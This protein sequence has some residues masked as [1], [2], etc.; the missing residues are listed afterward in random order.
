MEKSTG[1]ALCLIKWQSNM[2]QTRR[3]FLSDLLKTGALTAVG[4][5][6]I[7]ACSKPAG[8]GAPKVVIIG[9]GYGGATCAKYIR[10]FDPD[11]N[12]TLVEAGTRYLTC[13]F[14]NTVL[15][16]MRE[17]ASITLNY[18]GLKKNYG[19]NVIHAEATAI[20]PEKRVVTLADGTTLP[21]QRLVISPG[22][23]Y[24]WN[25]FFS[26]YDETASATMPH[27]WHGGEQLALLKQQLVG[28]RNGGVFA[29]V[30]PGTPFRCP[31][32]PYERASLV[33]HY[34]KQAN[35]R[36]KVLILD[37]NEHFSKQDLFEEAWHSLYSGMIEH[38][39]ISAG[40]L[41]S[42][43]DP[44]RM[45]LQAEAGEFKVDV[46]NVIPFQ[47]A[48]RLAVDHGLADETG[49]CPVVHRTFASTIVPDIHVLGDSCLA[50]SMPKSASSANSQAKA[51]SLAVISLLR[52]REPGA[53]FYHNTCYSLVAPDYGISVNT[54]YR[55]E[56]NRIKLIERAGG[57]SPLKASMDYRAREAA[58]A[59]SWYA[60]INR[61]SFGLN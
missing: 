32:G 51:C 3:H 10:Y 12:V 27:A 53:M 2:A 6:L 60:S 30:V 36:A 50:G 20:H 18:A 48:G 56:D 40:G 34:L 25:H 7:P 9:G 8:N 47:Q 52:E 26:G 24:L 54:M 61:D 22:I 15:G 45:S 59:R 58:Y 43:V 31:P 46:A 13:P 44:K 35:P 5:T 21:Y 33:A 19:I 4:G 37:A 11:I 16:G 29:I 41:V 23:S 14:S 38:V 17:A 57:L 42:R 49:W 55:F 39:P 1:S 28:M